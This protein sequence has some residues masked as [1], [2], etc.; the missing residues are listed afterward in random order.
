MKGPATS[1]DMLSMAY[2]VTLASSA[3]RSHKWI[4]NVGKVLLSAFLHLHS[5]KQMDR[6][7]RS[8]GQ[9]DTWTPLLTH[10]ICVRVEILAPIQSSTMVFA[11]RPLFDN[12]R[13]NCMSLCL[14]PSFL[15][16]CVDMLSAGQANL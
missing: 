13:C 9:T 7:R 1:I 14:A 8:H 4:R 16:V 2:E 3:W 6:Q 11:R 15:Q 10:R 5:D 12:R